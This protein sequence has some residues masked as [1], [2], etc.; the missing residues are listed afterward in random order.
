MDGV[1]EGEDRGAVRERAWMGFPGRPFGVT[2]KGMAVLGTRKAVGKLWGKLRGEAELKEAWGC[3]EGREKT[4]A[5]TTWLED[6]SPGEGE[7]R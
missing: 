2:L 6:A 1:G 7:Y 4:F 3:E 5:C